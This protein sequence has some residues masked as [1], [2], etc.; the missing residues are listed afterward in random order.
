MFALEVLHLGTRK[1]DV[2]LKAVGKGHLC[3]SKF[4]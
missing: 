4:I 3:V 2:G 1:D